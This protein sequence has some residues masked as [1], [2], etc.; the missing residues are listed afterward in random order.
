MEQDD[1]GV[2][3][4]DRLAGRVDKGRGAVDMID[5]PF[6]KKV[7]I[8]TPGL[9]YHLESNELDSLHAVVNEWKDGLVDL[10]EGDLGG[11]R[12]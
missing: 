6:G 7:D 11:V 2:A 10:I 1:I 4:L 9:Y 3:A 12:G 8:S 5:T